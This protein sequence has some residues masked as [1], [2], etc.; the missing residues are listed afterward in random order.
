MTVTLQSSRT[1]LAAGLLVLTA[2]SRTAPPGSVGVVSA[3]SPEAAAAGRAILEAGGNAVDAA[4]AAAFSLAVTEPAG[5]GLGGQA[6]FLVHPAGKEPYVLNG[7]THA[8]AATPRDVKAED[9]TGHRAT[10]VPSAVKVLHQAWK[11]HGSG[12]L[13]WREVLE[14]A[15]QDAEE[16]F[17]IGFFRH[18]ALLYEA[19]DLA[20]DATVAG[21]FLGAD[22]SIPDRGTLFKQPV[23]ARTLRRLAE[24]G[25]E[26]FYTGEIARTIAADMEAHGG[27]LT[28]EDLRKFPTP[29]A[30][31]PLRGTY[32][33]RDVYTLP[34]PA[35][36]WVVLQI[37]KIL[38]AAPPE[39]LA[40]ESPR[41]ILWLAEALGLGHASRDRA[42]VKDMD[43]YEE[44]VDQELGDMRIRALR[45]KVRRP[46]KGETTHISVVDAGGTAVS[47]TLSI[48]NFFGAR[49][50]SPDLGFL[51]NDYMREFVLDRPDHPFALKAGAMPYSSM[52]ATVLSRNGEVS[53]VVG[54]PGGRRIISAVVQVIVNR[55]DGGMTVEKAVAAPRIHALGAGTVFA[56]VP[57]ERPVLLDL[58]RRG[59]SVVVPVS[60]LG[61]GSLNPYFGGVHAV[62]REAGGWCGAADPRRDGAVA[63]AL[64]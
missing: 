26:D 48:N 60:S 6:I 50:A 63:V 37:L 31:P 23:L 27:W 7:T 19:K 51:Y 38:E 16:G 18:R 59:R 35:G 33:G 53:L 4:V 43:H 58:E 54:S 32:R 52:A 44:A 29:V 56:E 25:G 39:D 49:A 2:C 11:H 62:A 45:V 41:R 47:A 30:S 15:I 57:P 28:L 12:N 3:A 14:P 8:P 13:S 36:G 20:R 21:L 1:L 22:G 40:P 64:P 10:T 61:R 5:S 34:P 55:V 46:G 42:P 24:A 9:L 17:R